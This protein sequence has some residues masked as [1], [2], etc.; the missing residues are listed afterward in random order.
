MVL[1]VSNFSSSFLLSISSSLTYIIGLHELEGS[2]EILSSIKSLLKTL[3]G[4]ILFT[5]FY[6]ID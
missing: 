5:N 3:I 6:K 4:N 1:S 2:K